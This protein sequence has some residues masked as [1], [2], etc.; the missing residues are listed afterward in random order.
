MN[1]ADSPNINVTNGFTW[2]P[3]HGRH[4][5]QCCKPR[6]L[7]LTIVVAAGI[8]PQTFDYQANVLPLS[9]GSL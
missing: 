8:E 9:H 6:F 7:H 3:S 4:T 2:Y 1:V 5:L